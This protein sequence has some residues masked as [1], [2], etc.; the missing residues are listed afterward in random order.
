[1]WFMI[2]TTI[3]LPTWIYFILCEYLGSHMTLGK[4]ILH[5][6]V[7]A[8]NRSQISIWQ[9]IGRT[10]IRLIP[11][12]LTHFSLFLMVSNSNLSYT[13]LT[14]VNVLIVVYILFPIFHQQAYTLHDLLS[15]TT[16]SKKI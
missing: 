16:T 8:L 1:M 3:S 7:D 14:A 9:A 13:L 12:E 2:L 11:W 10:F 15:K 6:K 4:K 5:L